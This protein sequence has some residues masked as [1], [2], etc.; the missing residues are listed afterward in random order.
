M[1]IQACLNGA[2]PGDFHPHLPLTAEAMASQG[3]A[4]IAAGATDLHIHPRDA[5]GRESL[6]AV[7]ETVRVVRIA[8]PGTPIGVSTGQWIESDASRTTRCIEAWRQPPDYASVNLSERDA[9]DVLAALHRIGV[10]I[11]AGLSST[12]DAERLVTLPRYD[13]C[14]RV[15]IEVEEQE[16]KRAR[17]I[18]D[19]IASVLARTGCS[20]PI[21]LH[22]VDATVWPSI[23]L[24]G[25]RGWSTRVGFEDGK[26]LPNSEVA[27]SNAMLVGEAVRHLGEQRS[28]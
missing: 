10:G 25:Q 17:D 15:L 12:A 5:R 21:L 1:I 18:V 11:E 24:A 4:C 22:G 7:D 9:P 2:R 8:C 23:H 19:E 14:L 26:L 16:M 6:A 20:L 28:R 13:Q 27:T 3:A